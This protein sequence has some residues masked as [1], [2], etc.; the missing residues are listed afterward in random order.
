[1]GVGSV[2]TWQRPSAS[3]K[4]RAH[5][6][7]WISSHLLQKEVPGTDNL[8]TF[9]DDRRPV[10]VRRRFSSQLA[11]IVADLE[12]LDGLDSSR[13]KSDRFRDPKGS[14]MALSG[15]FELLGAVSPVIRTLDDL[16]HRP[17]CS[18]D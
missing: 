14:N 6:W 4:T 17:L 12:I 10:R 2:S 5:I 7:N 15:S 1:M 9:T 16:M 11:E 13:N 18:S 8:A 3:F